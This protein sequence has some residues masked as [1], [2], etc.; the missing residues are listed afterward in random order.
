MNLYDVSGLYPVYIKPD[1]NMTQ[2]L[3]SHQRIAVNGE[4]YALAALI[5]LSLYEGAVQ[6]ARRP[7]GPVIGTV[8]ESGKVVHDAGNG[9]GAGIIN[10]RLDFGKPWEKRWDDYV[11]GYTSCVQ[12]GVYVPPTFTD[13]YVFNSYLS[14]IGLG[15]K[16]GKPFIVEDGFV[17]LEGF[18]R[19]GI[20]QG[21]DTLVN[22][23]GGA[24]KFLWWRGVTIFGSSRV[25]WNA[26]ALYEKVKEPVITVPSPSDYPVP[27]RTLYFGCRGDDVRWLQ[28]QLIKHG[29]GLSCADGIFG[30]NTFRAVVA[31]QRTWTRW[32][33]GICGPNTRAHLLGEIK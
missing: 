7:A 20:A 26:L 24:S 8:I 30:P 6:T 13:R 22:V 17:T 31:Y 25:P 11:T 9:Y 33:D 32:P 23:D 2:W 10:G 29:Y 27:T 14:R 18:A 3:K 21:L 5:N 4:D 12:D 19:N 15:R 16:D 1:T 28:D